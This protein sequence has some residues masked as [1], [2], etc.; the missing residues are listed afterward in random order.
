MWQC[1]YGETW[2]TKQTPSVICHTVVLFEWLISVTPNRNVYCAARSSATYWVMPITS[3]SKL[4]LHKELQKTLCD[5]LRKTENSCANAATEAMQIKLAVVDTCFAWSVCPSRVFKPPS[6]ICIE[7]PFSL[8]YAVCVTSPVWTRQLLSM[9][10]W[11][12]WHYVSPSVDLPFFY[13]LLQT[14]LAEGPHCQYQ[15]VTI[16]STFLHAPD[17]I[18]FYST[19]SGLLFLQK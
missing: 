7:W 8:H 5:W 9:W 17:C 6:T 3:Y 12:T 15:W 11:R 2:N 16:I 18:Q 1:Q 10:F 4:D 19:N 14:H 13:L